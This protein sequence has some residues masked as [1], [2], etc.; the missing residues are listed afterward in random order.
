MLSPITQTFFEEPLD[1][2]FGVCRMRTSLEAALETGE[3]EGFLKPLSL[4]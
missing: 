3:L 4:P 1:S 2:D